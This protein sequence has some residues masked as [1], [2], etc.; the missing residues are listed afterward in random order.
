MEIVLGFGSNLGNREEFIN[1]SYKLLEERLGI[2]IKKSLFIETL[3]WGFKSEN[4]FLN[5]V[6]IFQTDKTPIEALRICNQIEKELG[7]VREGNTYQNRTIDI[8]ILFYDDIILNTPE[9]IIPHPLIQKRDFVL[10]PLKEILPNL[11]HP[12]LKKKIKDI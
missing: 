7:R 5:S 9:L 10:T 8:D 11:I 2:M 6:A 12:V 1:T 4:K 3:A